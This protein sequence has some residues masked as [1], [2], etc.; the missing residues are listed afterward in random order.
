MILYSMTKSIIFKQLGTLIY[1][2]S[3]LNKTYGSINKPVNH[4]GKQ[5][6]IFDQKS[7]DSGNKEPSD[8]S[9]D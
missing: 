4:F 1:L 7:D 6:K 5:S 2:N 8:Q 9:N 3:H